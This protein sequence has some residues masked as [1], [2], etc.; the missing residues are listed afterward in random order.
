MCSRSLH[1]NNKNNTTNKRSSMTDT[2]LNIAIAKS[3]GMPVLSDGI[4][5]DLTPCNREGEYDG[6]GKLLKEIPNFCK[7]LNITHDVEESLTDTEYDTYW[8]NLVTVCVR[9][10]RERLNSATA[11]QRAEALLVVL[12]TRSNQ[13]IEISS[14]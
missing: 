12:H 5:H 13:N 11:R 9:D 1:Q 4:R 6:K 8:D 2:E 10:G 7:N 3:L 14:N